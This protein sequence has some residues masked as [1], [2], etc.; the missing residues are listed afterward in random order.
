MRDIAHGFPTLEVRVT[1]LTAKKG[2]SPVEVY[3]ALVKPRRPR[4]E[5][6]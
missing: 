4:K 3:N 6:E 5:R 2:R 1:R